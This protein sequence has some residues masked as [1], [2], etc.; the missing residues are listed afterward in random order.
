MNCLKRLQSGIFFKDPFKSCELLEKVTIKLC[1][2]LLVKLCMVSS[3]VAIFE[4][5]LSHI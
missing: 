4:L 1:Y 5:L 2:S 3:Y